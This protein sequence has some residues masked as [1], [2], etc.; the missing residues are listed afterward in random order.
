MLKQ[1]RHSMRRTYRAQ[2]LALHRLAP[3]ARWPWLRKGMP[4]GVAAV[5]HLAVVSWLLSLSLRPPERGVPDG[6]PVV[7]V[8][9][10]PPQVIEPPPPEPEEPEP[11]PE[12]PPEPI[13]LPETDL[14]L[15]EDMPDAIA[16]DAPDEAP[17]PPPPPI[18][19]GSGFALPDVALPDTDQGLGTPD[20]LVALNCYEQFSDPDKAAECA[21]REILSGWRADVATREDWEKI[22]RDIRRGGVDVPIYGPDALADLGD[23]QRIY[24]PAD[25]RFRNRQFDSARRYDEAFASPEEAARFRQLQD[26]RR[27][28]GDGA[29]VAGGYGIPDVT[30]MSGWQPSWQLRDDPNID[31]REVQEYLRQAEQEEDD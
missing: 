26:P 19:D 20:G 8:F 5:A 29:G 3:F 12:E 9:I 18:D 10:V 17:P 24:R 7:S 14:P 2:R 30:P 15:P 13:D 23:R 21:G 31:E 25:P 27:Y 22:A 6:P 11:E 28:I 16:P 4:V 1:F